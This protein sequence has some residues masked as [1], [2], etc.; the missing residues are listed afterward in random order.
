M[1][2]AVG[3]DLEER[4]LAPH[5]LLEEQPAHVGPRSHRLL[6]DRDQR[7]AVLEARRGRGRVARRIANHRLH[8]RKPAD[9]E[10]PVH[11]EGE[12]EI[13]HRPREHDDHARENALLVERALDLRGRDLALALVEHLHVAA[14]GNRREHPLGLVPALA[15]DDERLAESHREPEDLHA[16]QA[17]SQVVAELVHHDEHADGDEEGDDGDEGVSHQAGCETREARR[18][19]KR[20]ASA[21]ASRSAA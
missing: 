17:R 6:G 14:E 12:E 16:Q 19:M 13:R 9:E 15:A 3:L 1:R 21:R 2:A 10:R 4:R 18:E 20:D 7:V 11:E 5:R 8:A